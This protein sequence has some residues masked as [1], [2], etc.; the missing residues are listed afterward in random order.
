[1]SGCPDPRR[2][3]R[4]E[5]V[6]EPRHLEPARRRARSGARRPA[7]DL[8]EL[9]RRSARGDEAAFAAALR[10]H[11]GPGLRARAPG[12][13]RPGPGRGGHPGGLPRDLA[14][15]QPVRPRQ[16]QRRLVAAD[17]RA[18]QGG[19]PG[20]LGR[21]G[22]PPGHDVPRQPTT[23]EHDSTAEAAEASFEARRVRSALAGA[24]RRCSARPSASPTSAVTRTPRWPRCSTS[25]SARP[26][27]GSETE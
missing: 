22:Q 25:R 3:T 19:R 9:L 27:P 11:V 14:D 26:R 20:P 18:P 8:A 13:P 24:D 21:G 12:R 6:T 10:R 15:R 16:G 23:V 17:D 7:T 2:R 4:I 5:Q 1:M